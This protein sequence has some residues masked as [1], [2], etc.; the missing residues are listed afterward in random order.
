MVHIFPFYEH[1]CE[2]SMQIWKQAVEA[3]LRKDQN[4]IITLE[5]SY[6]MIDI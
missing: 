6:L 2:K 5:D 3:S 1:I 4:V